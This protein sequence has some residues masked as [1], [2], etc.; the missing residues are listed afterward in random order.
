MDEA[1]NHK[2]PAFG[3]GYFLSVPALTVSHPSFLCFHKSLSDEI[4]RERES[5]CVIAGACGVARA[6]GCGRLPCTV[7]QGGGGG[8]RADVIGR[9]SSVRVSVQHAGKN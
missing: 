4:E 6:E 5:V 1:V 9:P 7:S 8:S 3:N 2:L